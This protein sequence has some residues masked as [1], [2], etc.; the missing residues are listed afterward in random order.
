MGRVR[1][2]GS[3]ATCPRLSTVLFTASFRLDFS[4][5]VSTIESDQ[6]LLQY[7]NQVF[8]TATQ[9]FKATTDGSSLQI[10]LE[11]TEEENKRLNE[12]LA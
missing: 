5:S 1:Q 11:K 2:L 3:S 4:T 7:T 8:V 9:E 6:R 12:M 10:K